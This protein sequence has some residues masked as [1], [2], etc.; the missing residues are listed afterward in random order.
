MLTPDVH[1]TPISHG[2][3][4]M[5]DLSPARAT[6]VEIPVCACTGQMLERMAASCFQTS[7]LVPRGFRCP[8]GHTHLLADPKTGKT[9]A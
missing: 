9:H 2:G 3:N 1:E 6:V 8:C 5:P 7:T 4:L